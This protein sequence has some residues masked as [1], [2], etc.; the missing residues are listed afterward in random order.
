MLYA[1]VV[2]ELVSYKCIQTDRQTG[3]LRETIFAHTHTTVI[4][5]KNEW[6]MNWIE[7]LEKVSYFILVSWNFVAHIDTSYSFASYFWE[8]VLSARI[9]KT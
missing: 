3:K 5:R 2:E 7:V 6:W 4:E 8:N 1:Q 9:M